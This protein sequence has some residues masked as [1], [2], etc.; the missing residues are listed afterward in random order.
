MFSRMVNPDVAQKVYDL[1]QKGNPQLWQEYKEWAVSNFTGLF[2]NDASSI[3]TGVVNRKFLQLGWNGNTGQITTNVDR[4][5]MSNSM[6]GPPEQILTPV[7][8]S[9]VG[10][11]NQ[12]LSSIAKVFQLDGR[13]PNQEVLKLLHGMGVD[14]S[15]PKE[16]S[17]LD[18]LGRAIISGLK[19]N[20]PSQWGLP[21]SGPA[22]AGSH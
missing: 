21:T 7:A 5:G 2:I 15:A 11:V 16:G 8:T 13:D 20:P 9:A 6:Q 3:Q 10:R 22:A 12:Q 17:A 18:Q 19:V 14:F 4:R 1:S